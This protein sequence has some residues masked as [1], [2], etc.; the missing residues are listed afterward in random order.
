MN[1]RLLAALAIV[2][3]LSACSKTEVPPAV[4]APAPA[5]AVAVAEAPAAALPAAPAEA[6][7]APAPAPAPAA[8]APAMLSVQGF[9]APVPAAWT[10]A[11]TSS[12]MRFAQFVIPAAGT[13]E[14]GEVAAF[15]FPTGNGGTHDMNIERWTSQFSAADGKPAKPAVTV[16][17]SGDTEVTLVELKGSYARGVGMGPDGQ[18][19]P[20]QTLMVAMVEIPGGR[21]TLQIYGPNKTVAAQRDNFLKV[22]RGFKPV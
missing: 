14:G 4:A 22:A 9:G 7:P 11:P 13:A 16:S 17:K 6:A 10:P 8:A 2:S 12:S 18:A 3:G 5:A 19:K 1:K 20:N 15:F 21:I